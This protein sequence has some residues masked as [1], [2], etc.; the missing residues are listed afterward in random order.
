MAEFLGI[1][2]DFNAGNSLKDR[3]GKDSFKLLKDLKNEGGLKGFERLFEK[4]NDL[5]E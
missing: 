2:Y 4:F 5:K 1:D 3:I